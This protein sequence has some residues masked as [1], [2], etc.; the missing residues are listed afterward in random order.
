MK[1]A[2][3]F[4]ESI[5]SFALFL[6]ITLAIAGTTYQVFNPNGGVIRWLT[7]VWDLN[8]TLLV[9]LGGSIVLF[10]NWLSGIQ[11]ARG[12]DLLFYGAVMLGLYYGFNL[13]IAA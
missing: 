6:V 2:A 11:A 10:R 7:R 5:S 1:Q 12:A 8:P 4:I 3:H 9:M 13:L